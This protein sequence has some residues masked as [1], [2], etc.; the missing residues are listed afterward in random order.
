MK[1]N[2][3]ELSHLI[4]FLLLSLFSLCS[5]HGIAMLD[6]REKVFLKK[7]LKIFQVWD[8]FHLLTYS[9]KKK[10]NKRIQICFDEFHRVCFQNQVIIIMKNDDLSLP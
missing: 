6:K 7:L 5:I 9:H 4:S 8:I 1:E 3:R 10:N 2:E